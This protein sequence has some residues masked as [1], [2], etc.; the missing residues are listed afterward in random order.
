MYISFFLGKNILESG[1]GNAAQVSAEYIIKKRRTI[2]SVIGLRRCN[3]KNQ[4]L[5]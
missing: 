5:I 4:E 2:L 1:W 3:R